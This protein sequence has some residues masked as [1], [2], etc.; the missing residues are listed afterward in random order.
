MKYKTRNNQVRD[1]Y[2]RKT[3]GGKQISE[4]YFETYYSVK[5]VITDETVLVLL[6]SDPGSNYQEVT[7]PEVIKTYQST[8]QRIKNQ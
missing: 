5:D 6:G 7:N 4:D 3:L 8:I 2:N 1:A